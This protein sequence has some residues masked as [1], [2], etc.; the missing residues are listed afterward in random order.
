VRTQWNAPGQ[1]P[2]DSKTVGRG[3]ESF[4]SCQS[5]LSPAPGNRLPRGFS[6]KANERWGMKASKLLVA[7]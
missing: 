1:S 3:F 6:S 7:T 2:T 5:Y 4:H